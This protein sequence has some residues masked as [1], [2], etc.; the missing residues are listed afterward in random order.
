M[1]DLPATAWGEVEAGE[2]EVERFVT[3]KTLGHGEDE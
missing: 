2:G 1:I 3:P